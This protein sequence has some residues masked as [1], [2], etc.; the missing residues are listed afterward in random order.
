MTHSIILYVLHVAD[1]ISTVETN[2]TG[3]AVTNH[4]TSLINLKWKSEATRLSITITRV[5]SDVI[6][7]GIEAKIDDVGVAKIQVK[8]NRNMVK[9]KFYL[10]IILTLYLNAKLTD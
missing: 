8:V 3:W 9:F 4:P 5:P 6:L 7:L 10:V 1:I 2:N